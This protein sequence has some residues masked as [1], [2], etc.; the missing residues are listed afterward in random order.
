MDSFDEFGLVC[1][2]FWV[3]RIESELEI[4]EDEKIV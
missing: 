3:I 2:S 1:V 4:M